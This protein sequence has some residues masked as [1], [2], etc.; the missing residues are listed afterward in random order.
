MKFIR[1]AEMRYAG[2]LHDIEVLLPE[3]KRG[4][5]FNEEDF[6]VLIQGFHE[7]HEA[8]YGYSDPSMPSIIA[9]LK[10]QAIGMRP[11]I[12]LVK[13]PFS[14]SNPSEALKRKREVYFKELGGFV[15]TPCYD[16]ERLRHGNII[17]GSA[18]IEHPQTTVVVPRG[19][20]LTVDSYEN[21]EIVRQDQ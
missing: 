16:D 18:I 4:E 20:E 15:E 13:Q 7:R 14:S 19:S 11:P 6:K 17:T 10:L 3:I 5:P 21:Y 8:I 1:G 2:Q 9:T 12:E